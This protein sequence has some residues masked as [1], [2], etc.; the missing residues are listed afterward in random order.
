MKNGR[1]RGRVD[2][3][4]TK[5]KIKQKLGAVRGGNGGKDQRLAGGREKQI[6]IDRCLETRRKAWIGAAS[7][8][9]RGLGKGE[10]TEKKGGKDQCLRDGVKVK[11]GCDL[12]R[13]AGTRTKEDIAIDRDPRAGITKIGCLGRGHAVANDLDQGRAETTD[14]RDRALAIGSATNAVIVHRAVIRIGGA[15]IVPLTCFQVMFLASGLKR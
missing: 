1:D 14:D 3:K 8:R 13:V 6:R 4:G 5:Q 10:I 12:C 15:V 11:R 9:D 2:G 7:G